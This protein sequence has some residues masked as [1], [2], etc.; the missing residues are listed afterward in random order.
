MPSLGTAQEIPGAEISC[1]LHEQQQLESA[2]CKL[3]EAS[4]RVWKPCARSV[5]F[6]RCLIETAHDI[7]DDKAVVR[8][9]AKAPLS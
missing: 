8:F 5:F 4:N 1:K 3:N 6:T 9:A 7:A 2:F